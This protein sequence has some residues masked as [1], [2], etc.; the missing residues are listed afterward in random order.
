MITKFIE[1]VEKYNMFSPG[2][3]VIVGLSGGADSMCLVSLLIK[4]RS[5]LGITVEAAHV[6]HCIRGEEAMRDEKFVREFCSREGIKVHV[7][8]ADIPAIADKTGESIELCARRVRYDFFDSLNADVIATA[9]TGSDRIETMLM[10]LSRGASLSG[11]CSIP[12]VRGNIVRPLISI[13]RSEIEEYCNTEKIEY[14]TDSTNLT[15]D[16]TRNKFR[17]N[18]VNE[19][20]SINP[21]FEKN[22][23]RCIE[24]INGDEI[25][26]VSQANAVYEKLINPDGS[27]NIKDIH[28]S[29]VSIRRRII[30][31][32][33]EKNIHTDLSAKHIENILSGLGKSFSVVLPGGVRISGN[34]EKLF[35]DECVPERFI[36]EDKFLKKGQSA[37]FERE[38]TVL[39]FEWSE[40]FP[41]NTE[42]CYIAAADRVGEEICIRTRR[43]GDIFHLGKR[44]CSK[45]LKKLFNEMK[46]PVKDRDALFVISDENGIIFLEKA[47]IDAKREINQQTSEFLIIKTECGKN[48]E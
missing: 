43:P 33:I 31:R 9:H 17:H 37:V 41:R 27:L 23:L 39:S 34:S 5:F 42:N 19:L 3:R 30:K 21:S 6:N 44:N 16:Y 40:K 36:Y 2:Q 18:V 22:A 4:N 26:L 35:Y 14:I 15:N 7:L 46:I 20:L 11:L 47:G 10:N 24:N 48:N 45:S 29:D 13:L 25:F 32:Y 28:L 38:G 1:T 12:P 8:S